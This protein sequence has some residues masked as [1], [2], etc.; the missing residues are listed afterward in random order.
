MQRKGIR[1]AFKLPL[2]Q[3]VYEA[4][5]AA[6]LTGEW[7]PGDL[8]P[9]EPKLME[10]FGVSRTTIRQALDLL[11]REGLL[12]RKQG[13]GTFVQA[14]SIEQNIHR[15]LSFTEDMLQRGLVPKTKVIFSGII[16]APQEI[17]EKLGIQPGEEVARLDRLRLAN[18][19]PLSV[20]E[21][22]LIH[23][24]C[25]GVLERHD[26]SKIPLRETLAKEYGIYLK[27]AQETIRAIAAPRNLVRLLQ[28]EN[29]A[30]LL[31]IER[32]SFDQYDRP[33]EYLR[34]FYRGDRYVLYNELQG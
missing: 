23:R 26:Y 15:I 2:Y 12:Q 4:L 17:A 19:E 31:Y 7:K 13:K 21:A 33:V 27:R 25:P 6:I 8:L 10:R 11:C 14:P 3:Q 18:D 22:H 24:L 28:I 30:P 5:R 20:E 9:P 32:V 16:E 34:K 29:N 1:F